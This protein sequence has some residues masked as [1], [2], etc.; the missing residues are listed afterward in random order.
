M[1]KKN[2]LMMMQMMKQQALGEQFAQPFMTRS[3]SFKYAIYDVW[4]SGK[5][6][7]VTNSAGKIDAFCENIGG[8]NSLMR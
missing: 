7:G 1:N 6:I 8:S 2:M 3:F 4:K 5:H